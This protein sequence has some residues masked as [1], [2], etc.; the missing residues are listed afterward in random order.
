MELVIT[1]PR[2]VEKGT[3][4]SFRRADRPVAHIFVPSDQAEA[5]QFSFFWRGQAQRFQVHKVLDLLSRPQSDIEA[6][7]IGP[8]FVINTNFSPTGG[9]E[10]PREHL[11]Y[12]HIL[13]EEV[14][15]PAS[16]GLAVKTPEDEVRPSSVY[17]WASIDTEERIGHVDGNPE[18]GVSTNLRDWGKSALEEAI[19]PLFE[20]TVKLDE[21]EVRDLWSRVPKTAESLMPRG[22][23]GGKSE[24]N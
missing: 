24:G 20:N 19:F 7:L 13:I 11:R 6:R 23:K 2:K 12:A 3:F 22:D 14:E 8:S 10:K 1:T 16:L 21:S 17:V 18:V 4:V 15:L 5:K 9:A